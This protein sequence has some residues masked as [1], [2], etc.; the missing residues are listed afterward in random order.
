MKTTRSLF[1][2]NHINKTIVASK[3][4]LKKAGRPST[5][6]SDLLASMM[7]EHPDYKVVEKEIK[8][9]SS[10]N[11]YDGLTMELMKAYIKTQENAKEMLEVYDRV[12]AMAIKQH[13]KYPLTKSWFVGVYKDF[14]VKKAQEAIDAYLIAQA[15]GAPIAACAQ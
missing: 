11:A 3:A 15:A 6:E 1:V 12:V 8:T 4:S 9:N 7:R 2:Y 13:K 5:A 14:D 10:K